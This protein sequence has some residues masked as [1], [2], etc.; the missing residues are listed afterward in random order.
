MLTHNSQFHSFSI[1]SG[2][3]RL[4]KAYTFEWI[5]GIRTA[6]PE[7]LGFRGRLRGLSEAHVFYNQIKKHNFDSFNTVRTAH[8]AKLSLPHQP[9]K[10]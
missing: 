7:I 2:V 4:L 6:L 9:Y 5:S 8:D 10:H 1:F 3:S